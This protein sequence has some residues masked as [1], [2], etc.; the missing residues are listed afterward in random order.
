MGK[1]DGEKTYKA[2]TDKEISRQ[3]AVY[4]SLLKVLKEQRPGV[5]M[6]EGA[7]GQRKREIVL[8]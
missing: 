5:V 1:E 2:K 7:V 3:R 6:Q 8:L 4:G